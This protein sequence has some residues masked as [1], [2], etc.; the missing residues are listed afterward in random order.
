MI[1]NTLSLFDYIQATN[2]SLNFKTMNNTHDFLH[3]IYVKTIEN[4]GY[5]IN[6]NSNVPDK[7]YMVSLKNCELQVNLFN[8][9]S[10]LLKE[11]INTHIVLLSNPKCFIGTW[12]END[13]V[14]IDISMNLKN[15][16]ASLAFAQDNGQIA[17]I[18][19]L[20]NKTVYLLNS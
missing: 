4:K 8:F 2:Y 15:R 6:L 19:V 12:I 18:D 14:F 20:Q 1:G 3:S 9:N 17:I 16:R 7:G 13:I 11:Y 10:R 5:S